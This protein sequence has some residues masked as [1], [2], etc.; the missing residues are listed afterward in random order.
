MKQNW[1]VLAALAFLAVTV[2][3]ERASARYAQ[4]LKTRRVAL[5]Q[6]VKETD[7][8]T[9]RATQEREQYEAMQG[10]LQRLNEQLRWEADTTRLIDWLNRTGRDL[11]LGDI[12]CRMLPA[13]RTGPAVAG[14]ALE[15]IRFETHLRGNYWPLVR[16]V[17]EIERSHAPMLIESLNLIADREKPGAGELKMIVSC[18][19]AVPPK[20]NSVKT[21]GVQ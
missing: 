18:L 16:Y 9:T 17:E 12:T 5:E 2:T 21:G 3:A 13:D 6:Q 11:G 20:N 1:L 10:Q 15:R 7:V 4:Q 14:G 8:R 19:W